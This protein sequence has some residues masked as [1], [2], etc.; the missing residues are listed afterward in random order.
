[1]GVALFFPFLYVSVPVL[2]GLG[3]LAWRNRETTERHIWLNLSIVA[4][5]SFLLAAVAIPK[6]AELIRKGN[7]GRAKGHLGFIRSGL[8]IYFESTKGHYPR[9]LTALSWKGM[10]PL[11]KLPKANT[12]AYHPDSDKVVYGKVPTDSGGWLYDNDPASPTSGTVLIDCTH[13]DSKG[14]AWTSY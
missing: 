14:T 9:E 4:L 13:T 5:V 10:P 3:Y 8:Q 1:M 2:A 6:Y 12:P 7:E 11:H